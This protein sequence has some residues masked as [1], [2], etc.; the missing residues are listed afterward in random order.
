MLDILKKESEYFMSII[1]PMISLEKKKEFDQ[2]VL[3]N[4]LNRIP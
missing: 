1:K 3:S 2:D 4:R